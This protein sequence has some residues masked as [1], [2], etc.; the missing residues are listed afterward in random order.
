MPRQN[1]QF[2]AFNRGV[3]SP[4][5]L[6]RI[7]QERTQLSAE[8]MTNWVPKTQGA[9]T[10]R[11][12]TKYLGSSINDS[13]ANYLEFVAATD[14]TA[15]IELTHEKMRVW[16]LS[17]TGNTW[18]TPPG[19]YGLDVPL[20]RPAVDTQISILDT[21][22]DDTSIGGAASTPA[23][24]II[25][26]MTG[27][28]T[29]GV[30]ITASSQNTEIVTYGGEAWRAADN[31]WTT[32]WQD[33]GAGNNTLPSWLNVDFGGGDTGI[34]DT[35]DRRAVTAYSIR[36]SDL[37]EALDNA[38]RVW[39]LLASNYDT[40]TFATDTG[41]WQLRDA[42]SDSG[43]N[44]GVSERRLFQVPDADT[45]TVEARR[46]YR[47]FVTAVDTGVGSPSGEL[48]IAE[49]ELTD[50]AEALQVKSSGGSQILNATAYGSLARLE[51]RVR[52]SD[53]GSE[54]ALAITVER[55]PITFRCGSS[56]QA[57][58]YIKETVLGTGYHNLAFVP[59]SALFYITFQTDEIVDRIISGCAISDSGTV[60]I[61]SPWSA[62]NIDNVRYDQSADVIYTACP[63][64]KPHKIERRG[65]GRSWSVVEYA[66]NTGP[67]LPLPTSKANLS[68]SQKYGNTTMQS[69]IPFFT[70]DHVGALFRLTTNGQSGVWPLGQLNAATDAIEITG[71]SD[72]GDT[73]TPSQGSERRLDISVSGIWSGTLDIERSYDGPDFG[74]HPVSTSGDY[75]QG[76]GGDTGKFTSDSGNQPYQ[77]TG[78]FTR[79]INDPDDNVPAW[80]RARISEWTSGVANVVMSYPGSETSGVAKVTGYSS[81]TEVPIEVVRRFS[82]TGPTENWQEGSWS[83]RQDYPSAV[84]LHGG[85]IAF[86]KGAT[87]TLSAADDYENFDET[88]EGDAAPIIRTLGSG[89]VDNIYYLLNLLRLVIGTAGAEIALRSSSLDEPV[90]PANSNARTFSTKGSANLRAVK[91]DNQGLFVHR[92]GT[93][94]HS[95]GNSDSLEG[96]FGVSELTILVPDFLAPGVVSIAVQRQP[97]TRIHCVMADGTVGILTFDP[98]EEVLCWSLWQGDTGTDPK[99][100]KAMVLPGTGED[101]VYYHVNRTIGG[102]TKRYL[103]RWSREDECVGDT[104]LTWIMDCAKRYSNDTGRDTVLSGFD[105]L[106]GESV[107]LWTDDTGSFEGVDRSPDVAGV[108]TRYT[109]DTGGEITMTSGDAHHAVA[110]LPYEATWKSTKLAYAS[111]AGSP[112]AQLKR[113]D[114]LGLILYQVHNN[115]IFFGQD[116]GELDAIPR[117]ADQSATV[118]PDKIYE[119]LDQVAIPCPGGWG[120][121]S[122]V[123]VQAKSPR[124]ATV[125]ALVP[126]VTTNE[127]V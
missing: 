88:T 22:W 98:I 112:L 97:D 122:R 39:R 55:G 33:T 43:T 1:A 77:D 27:P 72:T 5:A 79:T 69:D 41:K 36:A 107:V 3:V 81:P 57:D 13:G 104:G 66:P 11:P 113:V 46:H 125:L 91:I 78:T 120:P 74:F 21:G 49:F 93:R 92:S 4:K 65:T 94:V 51:R 28:I 124:P 108:Q 102:A 17:D 56:P 59:T 80:Y 24:N 29:D 117:T 40:G 19:G 10:I 90:T 47:L 7:D 61:T 58:D 35:G 48:D 87:L 38:P 6:A 30:R 75:F 2:L 54:H 95:I 44:W 32:L 26:I 115:G 12:G 111:Q 119:T 105:H 89:P 63:G 37:P 121:D 50:F 18:E 82:D 52:V 114:K 85:R 99:V 71:I 100:E 86:A 53:T 103:E 14:D 84:A 123:V 70:N 83:M 110:G 16:L 23:I 101:V 25:P 15:L 60:E 67:F 42:V 8:T 96:D 31:N 106:V 73:G 109:V 116:T 64:V 127:R 118:D 76:T 45:G 126:T 34:G 9:M 68:V 62:S 20:A